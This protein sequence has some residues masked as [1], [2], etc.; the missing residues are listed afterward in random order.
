MA[1]QPAARTCRRPGGR[2][3]E[4]CSGSWPASQPP[5]STAPAALAPHLAH[6]RAGRRHVAHADVAQAR[7]QADHRLAAHVPRA[8]KHLAGSGRQDGKVAGHCGG[9]AA[10]LRR[11]LLPGGHSGGRRGLSGKAGL[12]SGAADLQER[13]LP[14]H[15]PPLPASWGRPPLHLH[16][17]I[18]RPPNRPAWWCAASAGCGPA[19]SSSLAPAPRRGPAR[20]PAGARC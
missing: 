20:W 10:H 14:L 7:Q 5:P 4:P 15:L 1:S 16:P 11:H 9:L 8:L 13:A 18:H 6:S 2:H 12:A 3:A 17:S 19:C